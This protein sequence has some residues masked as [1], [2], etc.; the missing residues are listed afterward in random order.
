MVARDC[1]DGLG[2]GVLAWCCLCVCDGVVEWLGMCGIYAAYGE[3]GS[4]GRRGQARAE[5][6]GE[7]MSVM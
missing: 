4:K 1:A 3:E 5:E 6:S 2:G 7:G